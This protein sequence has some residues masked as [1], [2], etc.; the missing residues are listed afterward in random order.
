MPDSGTERN[1]WRAI[2]ISNSN[3]KQS[4]P[5]EAFSTPSQLEIM[6]EVALSDAKCCILV[7]HL[8]R[9]N[10]RNFIFVFIVPFVFISIIDWTGNLDQS[11]RDSHALI[12][13]AS[14][15]S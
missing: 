12:C 11:I 1:S 8:S 5:S 6:V 9:F 3:A 2:S 15:I 7:V 4:S 14:W 13:N 10:F